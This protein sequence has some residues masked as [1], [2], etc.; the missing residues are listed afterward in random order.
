VLEQNRE[1]IERLVAKII[2]WQCWQR[3]SDRVAKKAQWT[4]GM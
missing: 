2:D 3:L 1:C 4:N